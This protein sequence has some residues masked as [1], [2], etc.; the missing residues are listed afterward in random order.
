MSAADV[1]AELDRFEQQAADNEN[2]LARQLADTERRIDALHRD[3]LDTALAAFRT[4]FTAED[5]V[6]DLAPGMATGEAGAIAGVL[7]ALSEDA[8][9]ALWRELA[10]NDEDAA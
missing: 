6:R 7:D 2:C 8:A 1:R 3:T 5:S 9:A 10:D 4:V